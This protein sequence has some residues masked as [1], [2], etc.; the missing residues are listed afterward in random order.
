MYTVGSLFAGVGGFDRAASN[1]GLT[2]LWANEQDKF[3]CQTYR[4]NHDSKLI[5]ANILDFDLDNLPDVDILT[6]GF[7]CQPFSIAGKLEGFNDKRG[8]LFFRIMDYVTIHRPRVLF[9][10]NVANIRGHDKG[11][12][13]ETIMSLIRSAGYTPFDAILNSRTHSG[14]PHNRKRWFCVAIRD[15][16]GLT[17]FEFPGFIPAKPLTDFISP[18]Y[19]DKQIVPVTSRNY[20]ASLDVNLQET[21]VY[22]YMRKT[23]RYHADFCPALSAT[24]YHGGRLPMVYQG[25]KLRYF[26]AQE[27]FN[28][29]GY[30]DIVLPVSKTQAVKQAGNMVTVPLIERI[31]EQIKSFLEGV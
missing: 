4:A 11:R 21:G 27:C 9:L 26:S 6:A 19:D 25:G 8:N 1:A 23:L 20:K 15:Y 2:V 12:T 29:Q 5:E 3:A 13:Y 7:P 31:F 24:M 16:T 14:I 10:E 22:I 17:P 18:I 30:P 28:F